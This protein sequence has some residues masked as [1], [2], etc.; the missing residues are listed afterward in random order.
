[1]TVGA[2][3]LAGLLVGLLGGCLAPQPNKMDLV[4]SGDFWFQRAQY[5]EAL[6]PYMKAAE[7]DPS[8]AEVLYKIGQCHFYLRNYR[9]AIYWYQQ[10]IKNRPAHR[11]ALAAMAEAKRRLPDLGQTPSSLGGLE[12][13]NAPSPV[14]V[15]EGYIKVAQT[16]EAKNDLN[17]A[18]ENYLK[19]VEAADD[20][21][22][23]HAAL[24]RFYMK[25]SNN[26][27][28]IKQLKLALRLNPDEPRVAEDLARLS[29]PAGP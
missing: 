28:A 11:E 8:D 1:M 10:A 2:I 3:G 25:V 18:L 7:R 14:V 21:G 9:E 6:G 5:L 26:V 16:W 23:T 15:A 27:E 29:A 12:P 22:F 19:A 24:G 17:R 20:K 4:K 13:I